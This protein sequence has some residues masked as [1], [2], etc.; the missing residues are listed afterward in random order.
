VSEGGESAAIVARTVV[1][2]RVKTLVRTELDD[3]SAAMG[4]P[5]PRLDLG[6]VTLVSVAVG[7]FGANMIAAEEAEVMWGEGRFGICLLL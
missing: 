3:P 6:A 4:S 2:T 1:V 5:L 7:S